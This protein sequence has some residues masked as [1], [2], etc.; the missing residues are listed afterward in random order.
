MKKDSMYC[1]LLDC[2]NTVPPALR[3]REQALIV[4]TQVGAALVR[5]DPGDDD[6]VL[7]QIA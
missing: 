5:A 1:Y 3:V 7:G 6:V 2:T 4:R